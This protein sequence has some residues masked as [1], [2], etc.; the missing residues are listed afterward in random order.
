MGFLADAGRSNLGQ[1]AR[2]LL[3]DVA[4]NRELD[5]REFIRE[6]RVGR[7]NQ[8]TN[9]MK[10]KL[11]QAQKAEAEANKPI[12]VTVDPRFQGLP[13]VSKQFVMD[14]YR[15]RGTIDE[16][17][18]G[19]KAEVVKGL[20]EIMTTPDLFVNTFLPAVED[21]KAQYLQVQEMAKQKPQDP[22]VQAALQQARTAYEAANTAYYAH[23]NKLGLKASAP[24]RTVKTPYGEVS[25]QY[26]Y[27][28]LPGLQKKKGAK[29]EIPSVM[30]RISAIEKMKAQL[31]TTGAV[32]PLILAMMPDDIQQRMKAGDVSGALKALDVE[33]DYLIGKLPEQVR[34]NYGAKTIN[35]YD[36]LDILGE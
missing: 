15:S 9:I 27:H 17:G 23:L 1:V 34:K 14:F 10:Y 7:I 4:Q 36:P 2:T 25:E 12:D 21:K 5:Q 28:Y 6:A 20:N 13:D 26:G 33:K 31:E 22:K 32:D 29:D 30:K 18:V 3:S 35:P 24:E 16:R 19:P 11:E 8:E